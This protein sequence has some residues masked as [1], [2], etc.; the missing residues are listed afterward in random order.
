M[1]T[2]KI[3]RIAFLTFILISS[4]PIISAASTHYPEYIPSQLIVCFKSDS[5]NNDQDLNMLSSQ[6]HA[7]YNATILENSTLLGIP[8]VQLIQLPDN[9][10]VEEATVW[11]N[12]KPSILYAEPNF[13]KTISLPIPR[14]TEELNVTDAPSGTGTL[15]VR[16]ASIY[17]NDPYF[18]KQWNL[19]NIQLPMA[20]DITTGSDSVVI[21]VLDTGVNYNHPDIA[22]NIWVNPGEIPDNNIDD[23]Q[24]GFIDDINGWDFAY[25]DK[26]PLDDYGH[27]T[28]IASIIGSEGNNLQGIAGMM[29]NVKIMPVKIFTSY[30]FTISDEIKGIHYAKMNGA[31]IIV[32]S[33]SGDY[34]ISEQ[35]AIEQAQNILFIC[36]AGN[37]GINT[38]ITPT[39]P[40]SYSYSNIMSVAATD[41]D[42]NLCYFSNYGQNRVDV[43]APGTD[44][45]VLDRDSNYKYADGTSFSAPQVA[46]L[47]GLILSIDSTKSA[48]ELRQLI[49]DN[50]DITQIHGYVRSG[51]RINAYKTLLAISSI[52]TSTPT[53][54]IT[55]PT[56]TYTTT[57]PIPSSTTVIPTNTPTNSPLQADFTASHTSGTAPLTV[58][59]QDISLGN[60]TGWMWDING[61]GFLDYSEKS[62]EHTYTNP[63]TYSITFSVTRNQEL[64]T[65]SRTDYIH[66]FSG[67]PTSPVPTSAINELTLYVHP[68]WNLISTPGYLKEGH[69]TAGQV[70]EGIDFLGHSI[71]RYNGQNQTWIQVKKNDEIQPLQGLWVYSAQYV[72]IVFAFNDSKTTTPGRVLSPGWNTIG[73]SKLHSVSAK[74]ALSSVQNS[75]TQL[76]GF[77]AESQLYETSIINS[78]SGTHSDSNQVYPG[79]GY[80]VYMNNYVT[81]M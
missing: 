62:F 58:R 6:L 35:T 4:L 72:P 80:W 41:E 7:E 30:S 50:V 66:V 19:N 78:G 10:S 36:A 20:W 74:D 61:D 13:I 45:I 21:A 65:I 63:G 68:G 49:M 67:T 59:F 25:N 38:D 57:T 71:F 23:D 2:N 70:F 31:K 29:W 24:N 12:S 46:G 69:H 77:N 39:Y 5:F 34:Y 43:G 44:I 32:C 40:A 16:L 3:I 15:S 9:V 37:D 47:A 52:S 26:S 42:D 27:G 8:G 64:A 17:P 53:T 60:P 18:S 56:P 14:G 73:F 79:K 22:G 48:S 81:L 51:G 28:M 54:Q 76:I 11:Y 1:S 55:T 75:W 33:F